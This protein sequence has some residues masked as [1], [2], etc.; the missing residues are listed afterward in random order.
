ME[1]LVLM[2]HEAVI[3]LKKFL[4]RNTISQETCMVNT[5]CQRLTVALLCTATQRL[6][7]KAIRTLTQRSL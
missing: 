7:L 3:I 2:R 5:Y 6:T 4:A 1:K